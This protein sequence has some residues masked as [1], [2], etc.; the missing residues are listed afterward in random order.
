ME[1][2]I[3]VGLIYL[4]Y[5][6]VLLYVSWTDLRTRR[7]PNRVIA[8]A[9]VAALLA[10]PWTIGATSALLGAII[11]PL[12]L[13]AGRLISGPS[14]VGMGDIK[15]AIF[16]GLILGYPFALWGVIISLILSLAAGGVGMAR[17]YYT[18]RSKLP[19]GPF[20][21]AGALLGFVLLAPQL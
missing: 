5:V 12:P 14:Q 10:M 16:I 17:G 8:P 2:P 3:A 6:A 11:A 4:A 9:I 21:A 13:I 1:R 15:L 19:F 18:L 7:I 20:L